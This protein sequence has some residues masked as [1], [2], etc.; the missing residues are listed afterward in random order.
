MDRRR[1]GRALTCRAGGGGILL[2][3]LIGLAAVGAGPAPALSGVAAPPTTTT[4]SAAETKDFWTPERLA[5]AEPLELPQ[6]RSEAAGAGADLFSSDATPLKSRIVKNPKKYPNR[7]HGKLFGNYPGV[8][9]FTCSA[10]VVSSKSRSLIT[11]AGHCLYD[12]GGSNQFANYLLFV[13]AFGRY[14]APYGYWPVTN[15]ITT[16]QWVARGSLDYDLSMMRLKRAG[17]LGTTIQ[18]VVGSR[19]IGFDQPRHQRLSAYGY[20]SAGRPAY[21]GNRLVRCD[22][23]YIPDP[24]K[25]GGPRSRGMRCD[26]QQGSSGGGWVAQHSFVVS[27]V[28]HGH[29]DRSQNEFFGPYYGKV[30][31]SLYRAN[32][33]GYPSIGPI[34]C[35]GKVVSIAGTNRND[36]IRGTNGKDIIATLGGNDRVNGRGGR[37]IICGGASGDRIIGGNGKDQIDGGDGYDRC[38]GAGDNDNI[39]HCERKRRARVAG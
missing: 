29:P 15:A 16:K 30:A 5:E 26:Q 1:H 20:P 9:L 4:F 14:S 18:K 31:K 10:T 8:G 11:S 33:P 37:D 17:A 28:S 19:G 21:G 13:P 34:G 7:V 23:G 39:R 27:N 25:H 6:D 24:A 32:G 3:S 22:S 35:R 2:I 12:K 36:K 38:G